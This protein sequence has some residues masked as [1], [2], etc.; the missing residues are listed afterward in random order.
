MNRLLLTLLLIAFVPLANADVDDVYYCVYEKSGLIDP[1]HEDG[2]YWGPIGGKFTFKWEEA[3]IIFRY[4]GSEETMP[5]VMSGEE[6][7]TT[8]MTRPDGHEYWNYK[9][10]SLQRVWS[11]HGNEISRVTMTLASCEKF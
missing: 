8:L 7:F 10:E 2:S 11:V 4:E 6:F 1:K 5:I 9:E 3:E